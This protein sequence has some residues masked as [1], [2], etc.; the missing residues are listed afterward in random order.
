MGKKLVLCNKSFKLATS[1]KVK[2]FFGSMGDSFK[3][4]RNF[5][6]FKGIQDTFSKES[7]T[8][9]SS[10]DA[11]HGS[12]TSRSNTSGDRGHV[13]EESH[14]QQTE[15][16]AGEFLSNISL[17]S[18][19]EGGNRPVV[20]LRYLNQFIL[21]QHF[22]MEGLFCLRE[23]LQEGDY[24][25]KMDMKDAYFSILLHQSSRN[26]VRFSWSGNIYEFFFLRLGLGL[27]PRIFTKM[28]KIPV[29]VLRRINIRMVIHLNNMLVMSQTMAE[30]LMSRG[31]VI[32]LL[33]HLGFVLK[34]EKSILN[35][36]QEIE[37]SG[38]K[39]SSLKMCLSLPHEKVLK[40]RVGVRMFMPKVR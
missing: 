25:C 9:E 30:I 20:N 18:K 29:S 38:V 11:T 31:T 23:I 14:I 40:F 15:H 13:E 39:I 32:F 36:V 33:Q 37:F 6:N 27:V 8:G 5:R 22:K 12:G 17:V 7:N 16:Q 35:P 34:L 26:Y 2:T 3:G 4:S 1:K 24:M 28:L 21:Y 10:P 19:R